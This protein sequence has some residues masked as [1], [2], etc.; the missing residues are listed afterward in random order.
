MHFREYSELHNT[1]HLLYELHD[2][3]KSKMNISMYCNSLILIECIRANRFTIHITMHDKVD[4]YSVNSDILNISNCVLE[5]WYKFL[6]KYS[7]RVNKCKHI[8][9]VVFHNVISTIL[10]IRLILSQ[11]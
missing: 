1:Y 4:P 8:H 7:D 2:L 10:H 11:R 9:E 5:I 6:N 3:G